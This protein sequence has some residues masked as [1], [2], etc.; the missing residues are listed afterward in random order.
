MRSFF[1]KFGKIIGYIALFSLFSI[2]IFW[3]S[4]TAFRIE[5]IE[6]VGEGITVAVN[7]ERLP[8]SLVFF[9]ADTYRQQIL[10]ANPV[11]ADITFRKKFPHTLVIIPKIRTPM[12]KLITDIRAVYLDEAGL[13]LSEADASRELPRITL[14]EVEVRIGQ[15]SSDPRV[16][17]AV[18]F[19]EGARAFLPVENITEVD[20]G[21]LQAKSADLDIIFPQNKP[22]SEILTTLQ[23]LLSGFRIKGTLPALVDLRFDKPIIRF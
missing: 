6:I 15:R 8:K 10:D 12:S 18:A 19:I 3:I 13:V 21:S 9:S 17:Q 11:L 7:Q 22:M 1:R 5:S 4:S 14:R 2:G 16:M 20:G 23:T